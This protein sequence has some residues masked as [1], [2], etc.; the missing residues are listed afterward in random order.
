MLVGASFDDVGGNTN[1]GSAHVFLICQGLAERQK[2]T[3]NNESAESFDPSI[4]ISG[5]TAVVGS[6][7]DYIG[8]NR[9]NI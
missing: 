8:G 6:G 3:T 2:V 7:F 9:Q 1:Q 4:A 5:D